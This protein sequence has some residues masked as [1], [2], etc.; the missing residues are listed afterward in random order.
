M[1]TPKFIPTRFM[2]GGGE[3]EG[4]KRGFQGEARGFK[5]ESTIAVVKVKQGE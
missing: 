5:G 2:G 3:G 4:E 1:G